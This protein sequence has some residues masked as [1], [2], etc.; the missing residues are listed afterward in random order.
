MR[1][2]QRS[3]P[4]GN[5]FLLDAISPRTLAMCRSLGRHNVAAT[6]GDETLFNPT[7]F[8]RYCKSRVIYPSSRCTPDAFV[9]TLLEYLE[10]HPH[11]CMLPVK[12]ESI[13]AI[14]AHRNA[15]ENLT[16]LPF[17]D[18]QTFQL[19]RDKSKT[20]AL[21]EKVGVPYPRT[22]IPTL[23]SQIPEITK[24]MRYPLLIKPRLNCSGLGI[25][26]VNKAEELLDAYQRVHAE[27][28]YPMI[29]EQIP[30]GEKYD[31]ACLCDEHSRPLAIFAQREI[32][33]FPVQS[34]A[35][36]LQESVSRPDLVDLSLRLLQAAN[37]Y[38]IAEVEFMIDPR[39]NTPMLMEVNPRF[40]GSLALAIQCGV[41]FPYLLYCLALGKPIEPVLTYPTGQL[42]RQIL[43]YDLLHFISNPD[44]LKL[45]PSF[46]DFFNP[47]CG[48]NLF[49][50]QDPAPVLG[51]FFSCAHYAF[52]PEMWLHLARMEKFASK[53]EDWVQHS[54]S[55][56]PSKK[57]HCE[58]PNNEI[59]L[60]NVPS[61]LESMK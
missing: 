53:M 35:S 3:K 20:I 6:C 36:T 52:D 41:D 49:S 9:N 29:Q 32:R 40:W 15:F 43:P 56:I 48:H 16:R 5:A 27:Y 54:P 10:A 59:T 28:P 42:C 1:G 14:L 31:V 17:V 8:S 44:R 7:F 22:V 57:D 45:Q 24:T 46:F 19:F 37:W 47:S 58:A 34:G 60:Q 18:T 33:S 21:A 61:T 39:D 12:E 26:Y 2:A 13:D 30:T 23:I 50:A 38:G 4:S 25:V 51:F 11:D 55:P